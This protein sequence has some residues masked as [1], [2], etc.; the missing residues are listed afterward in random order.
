MANQTRPRINV[1]MTSFDMLLEALAAVGLIL[2]LV[3]PIWNFYDLPDTIPTH[4]NHLGEPD[5]YGSKNQVW[6]LPV[7]G[8]GLFVL[9][10]ILARFPHIYNYAVR[11]TEENAA[12]QYRM[13][14]YL[15]RGL[16]AMCMLLFAYIIWATVQGALQH[17]T[18]L[19]N[20]VMFGFMGSIGL[21]LAWYIFR[22]VWVK[23]P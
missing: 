19:D 2:L 14:V 13:A 10:T 4:F 16:K 20:R 6:I 3:L 5:Q 1:E 21:F 9:F 8:T 11:I 22:S 17:G 15:I 23:Q 7:L 12:S 18:P